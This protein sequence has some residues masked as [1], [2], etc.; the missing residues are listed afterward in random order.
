MRFRLFSSTGLERVITAGGRMLAG[1]YLLAGY[2][3][4]L[5]T[6]T[7]HHNADIFHVSHFYP[8]VLVL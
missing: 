2:L 1:E 7:I 3:V 8:E 4:S 5:P 6:L